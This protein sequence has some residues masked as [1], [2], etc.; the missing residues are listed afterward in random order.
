M[1]PVTIT[2]TGETGWHL[3]MALKEELIHGKPNKRTALAYQ[4]AIDALVA[5]MDLPSPN[6]HDPAQDR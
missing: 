3:L 1:N 6:S 2:L 5:A 4:E